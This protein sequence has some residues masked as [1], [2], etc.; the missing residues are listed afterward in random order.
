MI[1]IEKKEHSEVDVQDRVSQQS[2]M[3]NFE[4]ITPRIFLPGY[5]LTER[6]NNG[7]PLSDLLKNYDFNH[8][9]QSVSI[10]QPIV[11]PQSLGITFKDADISLKSLKKGT[12]YSL[13][14]DNP[15]SN[16][17]NVDFP[18]ILLYGGNKR[19]TLYSVYSL[20]LILI[21]HSFP[22]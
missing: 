13:T 16:C 20:A 18:S 21:S 11:F 1:T 22:L 14:S 2:M 17:Y 4:K 3:V 8:V 5:Y 10:E 6:P 12:E 19:G 15:T 9:S 7:R